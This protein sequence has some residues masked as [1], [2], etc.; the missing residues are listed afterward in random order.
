MNRCGP[1]LGESCA[2]GAKPYM[3]TP[4]QVG[5]QGP[6]VEISVDLGEPSVDLGDPSVDLSDPSVDLSDPTVDLGDPLR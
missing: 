2:L 4:R 5:E 1:L 3:D 6:A